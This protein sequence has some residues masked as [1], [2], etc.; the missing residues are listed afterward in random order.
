M[1]Q[2]PQIKKAE[3]Q[4]PKM[5]LG[6]DDNKSL[7]NQNATRLV[8]ADGSHQKKQLLALSISPV[9]GSIGLLYGLYYAKKSD[10][11]FLGYVEYA[12]LGGVVGSTVGGLLGSEY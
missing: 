2:K 11:G 5:E 8:E 4:L 7:N 3:P 12:I 9:L 6:K 10:S 1:K